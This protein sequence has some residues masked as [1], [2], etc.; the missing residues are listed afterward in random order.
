M[1]IPV[2]YQYGRTNLVPVGIPVP[3][4][5][6]YWYYTRRVLVSYHLSPY[7]YYISIWH[8]YMRQVRYCYVPAQRP[9]KARPWRS[10]TTA[11]DMREFQK[12]HVV[13]CPPSRPRR[14]HCCCRP[15]RSRGR[16]P[17]CRSAR[18]P[19]LPPRR[20]HRLPP[21]SHRRRASRWLL[22]L[23]LASSGGGGGDAC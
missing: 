22:L 12:L 9:Y 11:S 6:T 1:T 16:R 4:Q 20:R 15:G 10:L 23:P 2:W 14:T 13:Q 8:G 5:N 7:Q 3:H 19:F 18:A 17:L 21:H